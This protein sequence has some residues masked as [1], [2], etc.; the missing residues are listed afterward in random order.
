MRFI[1]VKVL[2]FKKRTPIGGKQPD[3]FKNWSFTSYTI[4]IFIIYIYY[5][6]NFEVLKEIWF[7]QTNFFAD[8]GLFAGLDSLRN[9]SDSRSGDSDVEARQ[10][11]E[12]ERKKRAKKNKNIKSEV[13]NNK[14]I[15]NKKFGIK[16][17]NFKP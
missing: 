17:L 5:L 16:F 4:Y 2:K 13:N 11:R 7:L 3:I 1:T 12:D 8:P 10:R 15:L 6:S 9:S 14:H